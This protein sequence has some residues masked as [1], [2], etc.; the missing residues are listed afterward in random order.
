MNEY[1]VANARKIY[2]EIA[3][4]KIRYRFIKNVML[5]P[6]QNWLDTRKQ[7]KLEQQRQELINVAKV[8]ISDIMRELVQ[9]DV[10]FNYG[11]LNAEKT[12]NICG[13]A[14][15]DKKICLYLLIYPNLIKISND[16]IT[17]ATYEHLKWYQHFT[18]KS[19]KKRFYYAEDVV[20]M[21]SNMIILVEGINE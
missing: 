7:Y 15:G 17:I 1:T 14:Y 5:K 3:D 16:E 11:G 9:Y 18:K 8:I 19:T 12:C 2:N 4:I 21:I 6:I 20:K 10:K 13:I